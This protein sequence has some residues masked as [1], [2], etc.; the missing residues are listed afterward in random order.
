MSGAVSRL[1][2]LA[3]Q[4]LP[5][6]GH[7][8]K[9]H[10]HT[11]SP[12]LFLP[13]AAS[14]EPD[15]TAVVHVTANNK[16]L[17]RSYIELADRARGL[18][19]FLK[20]H[21]YKRVGILCPNT[22]AFL[23]SY[24]GIAAAGG[25]SVAINYRLKQDDI[26]YIFDHAE[27]DVIIVDSE[28]LELLGK[29][30][31]SH[32]KTLLIED[33]D[34]DAV[35]GQLCG[36]FDDAVL[37]GLKIDAHSGSKG[38][39]G[40]QTQA[41]DEDSLFSLAYTSGT[42][43]RPKGVEYTHRGVYLAALANV[44]ESGLNFHRDRCKYLWTLPMFHATG[45]TF[46]WSVTMVRGTHYCLRK[47]DYAVIWRLLKDEGI[48]H[49]S[50]A[51][52][53]NTLLCNA[54]Q[55]SKLDQPVRV[56]VA[57]SPPTAHLFQQM[58][59]LNLHPVHV[60]GMT[61][62]YGP[63]TKGYYMPAWDSLP[64][65]ER[66]AKMA[67]QG[68]GFIT[69]LPTRVIKTGDDVPEGTVVDVK[70]DGKE[71]GEIV[72]VGNICAKGYYKNPEA[73]KKLFAGGVLHS[74]DLAVWHEDGAIQILDRAKDIIISGGENISSVAL[75]S[76]LANH[77]DILEAAVIGVSDSHWGERPK[78]FVTVQSG[79]RVTGEEIID[80]AKHSSDI[81]KFM[82]PREVE[83]ISELPKTSTGKVKKTVLR[84]WAKGA[85]RQ[86]VK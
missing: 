82:V 75:E 4:L 17:R 41:E 26:A 24:F 67:R 25:V 61:E 38:W 49:F 84:E 76:M 30:R 29:Y 48:T 59:A 78:A 66:F 33:T 44:V 28:Y 21:G 70:K 51:P 5:H 57:A 16:I 63:I 45:W 53:V 39:D 74:G 9:Q 42:T 18:A 34:T 83:I 13:R 86:L 6:Q 58:T 14:I 50:A 79:R 15:A 47:I 11:L 85:D 62:T 2:Q 56:A 1:S 31:E 22:P 81:S 36:P 35:E 43:A 60:Y 77:P 65:G 27:V 23:E 19:Y 32:P 20:S 71:I 52:T 8:H 55:A 46:P 7:N 40:L 69:S 12:T 80:W 3:S 54:E 68:H 10:I 64:D 72:F 37:E 73:T